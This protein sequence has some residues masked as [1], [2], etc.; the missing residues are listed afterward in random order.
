MTSGAWSG[1]RGFPRKRGAVSRRPESSV[2]VDI[3]RESMLNFV[4]LGGW[5]CRTSIRSL[6]HTSKRLVSFV[7]RATNNRAPRVAKEAAREFCDIGRL[8]RRAWRLTKRHDFSQ[9]LEISIHVSMHDCAPNLWH[10]AVGASERVCGPRNPEAMRFSYGFETANG[11]T[12]HV[13]EETTDAFCDIGRLVRIAR[14]PMKKG[15]RF[16]QDRRLGPFRHAREHAQF[17]DIGRL[18]LS[19]E[20]TIVAAHQQEACFN[21]LS[22]SKESRASSGEGGN[23]LIL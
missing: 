13:A 23:Q 17:C 20:H 22:R 6:Q 16:T 2:H 19:H 5:R 4:A 12:F 11:R 15:R 7:F 18:A 21:R 14:P 1:L 3:M 8:V 10:C 9:G